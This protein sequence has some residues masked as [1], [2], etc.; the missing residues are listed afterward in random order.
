MENQDAAY[1]QGYE[2]GYSYYKDSQTW[3]N[4]KGKYYGD[5]IGKDH[6]I[7]IWLDLKDKYDLSFDKNGK[8]YGQAWD[9]HHNTTYKL[10]V[11]GSVQIFSFE[12]V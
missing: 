3:N 4:N 7:H 10:A 9:A 6:I 5:P 8:K 12:I 1:F 2:Y 11:R